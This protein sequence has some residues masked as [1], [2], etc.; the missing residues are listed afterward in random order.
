M[1]VPTSE[2]G[3]TSA[4][5]RR[6][7]HESSYERVV[8]LE[9][10]YI[11]FVDLASRYNS[12]LMTNLKHFSY[13]FIYY[14]SLHVSSITVLIIRRSNCINT[15]SGMISLCKSNKSNCKVHVYIVN[16]NYV[17]GGMLFTIRIEQLH[18]SATIFGHHPVVQ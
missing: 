9:N 12:L 4:A 18:V 8:A 10:I 17:L 6:G 3:Y 2:V 13:I 5:A 11:Y 16:Y 7:D 14:T 1:G 15:S